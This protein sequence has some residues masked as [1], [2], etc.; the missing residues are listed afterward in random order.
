M[1][2][3]TTLMG[4]MCIAIID[5]QCFYSVPLSTYTNIRI[6]TLTFGSGYFNSNYMKSSMNVILINDLSKAPIYGS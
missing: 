1:N 2:A 4:N 6:E 5:K 3:E